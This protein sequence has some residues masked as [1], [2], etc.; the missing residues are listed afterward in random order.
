LARQ[1]SGSPL[2]PVVIRVKFGKGAYKA[3]QESADT[4]RFILEQ[5]AF[6][7]TEKTF[8]E[9]KVVL[10]NQIAAD[11]RNELIHI[12]ALFRKFVIG[13]AGSKSTATGTLDTVTRGGPG[14][15]QPLGLPRWAPRG[16][17]YLEDKKSFT[18]SKAWFDNSGGG[19]WYPGAGTLRDFFKPEASGQVSAVGG[20]GS[21]P[22]NATETVFEE[23][24]GK[25]SVVVI[26]NNRGN[27]STAPI[28]SAKGGA[29]KYQVQ[30]ATVRVRAFGS[31]TDSMLNVSG[32]Y[33]E[34]LMGRVRAYDPAI[35]F[36]LGGRATKY[37]PT[38]EPFLKFFQQ[39]SIEH[40]VTARISKGE[41]TRSLFRS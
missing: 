5:V 32:A 24:F 14:P 9:A 41:L 16:A 12:E 26:R 28:I 1:T 29:K 37:R 8:E 36:R 40:A 38:L 35:A 34:G 4:S 33:N 31:I 15:K 18:G 20:G 21:F 25:I 22:G 17:T 27:A 13:A 2:R 10:R 3:R 7:F 30:L 11:V 6:Q 19:G 23:M 39:K